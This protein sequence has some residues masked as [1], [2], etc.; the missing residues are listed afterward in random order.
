MRTPNPAQRRTAA[1]LALPGLYAD[2]ANARRFAVERDLRL[3][4]WAG[5]LNFREARRFGIDMLP[6][7]CF[8][9]LVLDIGANEGQF[10]AALLGVTDDIRIVAFEPEPKTAQRFSARFAD[11]VDVELREV[12]LS[13][14]H[15]TADLHV[16]ENS[17]FAS[18]L[19]PL[20]DITKQY[21][22]GAGT[23]GTVSVATTTLDRE[24]A[25][26]A[27]EPVGLLKL[28]VQGGERDVLAGAQQTLSRTAAILIEMNFAPHYDGEADFT[29]LHQTLQDAGFRLHGI[30]E[31]NRSPLTGDLLWA[32]ACYVASGCSRW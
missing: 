20:A 7:G 3:R 27:G 6:M 23:V 26:A 8:H 14:E 24:L 16:T 5:Y 28:D 13:R 29:E 10:A 30:G 1:R 25:A 19:P 17:V 4:G 11:A 2:I 12:A 22:R 9:G 31:L 15:G 32:D 21:P 18:L